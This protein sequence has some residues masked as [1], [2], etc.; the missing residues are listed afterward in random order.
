VVEGNPD[1]GTASFSTVK[2]DRDAGVKAASGFPVEF[3]LEVLAKFLSI[4]SQF[5][6]W[7][8]LEI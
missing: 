7:V 6:L 3:L 4:A 5:A 2:C 8:H 1:H